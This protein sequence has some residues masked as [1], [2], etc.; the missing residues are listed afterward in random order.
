[1]V[2]I[3]TL[4]KIRNKINLILFGREFFM[5]KKVV[6]L[7]LCFALLQTIFYNFPAMEQ[8]ITAEAA[9]KIKL[10]KKTLYITKG[11]TAQLEISGTKKK[12]K[13]STSNK[14]IATVTSKG[15]VKG[16]KKGNAKVTATVDGKKYV[17]KVIV[18]T[19]TLSKKSAVLETGDTITLK[20]KDTKQ[21]VK[22]TT[23][24]KSVAIVSKNGVVTAL[25]E[26]E[27]IITAK[28][29]KKNYSCDITVSGE[30]IE[31][32]DND[33]TEE[34][35]ED[36]SQN[37]EV[38]ENKVAETDVDDKLKNVKLR[39]AAT[40]FTISPGARCQLSVVDEKNNLIWSPDV[41]SDIEVFWSSEKPSIASISSDGVVTGISMGGSKISAK[42]GDKTCEVEI[43]VLDPFLTSKTIVIHLDS[44]NIISEISLYA[45]DPSQNIIWKTSDPTVATILS[46]NGNSANII[47]VSQGD[48]KIFATLNGVTYTCKA[49]VLGN[50]TSNNQIPPTNTNIIPPV[51]TGTT[52]I[53]EVT[54]TVAEEEARHQKALSDIRLKVADMRRD[55]DQKIAEIR[56]NTTPYYGT[57]ESYRNRRSDLLKIIT[58]CQKRIVALSGDNSEDAKKQTRIEKSKMEA[59][60]KEL[61]ELEASYYAS[62][63]ISN[64]EK[65]VETYEKAEMD[66]ENQLYYSNLARING[67]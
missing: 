46:T 60:Q 57:E 56:R 61:D 30:A 62:E 37:S 1:M 64:L 12:V 66:R 5:K 28:V 19:P 55:T 34:E 13:W 59:A 33:D 8:K 54:M 41:S 9:S 20:L 25:E 63:E 48:C 50:T 36:N 67:R 44:S 65:L 21:S 24:N 38:N 15:R 18:E 39:I 6:L 43:A 16:V 42:I 32:K 27:T 58:Q 45:T 29:G 2:S 31:I 47:G 23:S 52:T 10:N 4:Y 17:C 14:K 35:Q 53:P 3:L 7:M 22:W 49:I 26:G 51:N 40:Q 11:Q